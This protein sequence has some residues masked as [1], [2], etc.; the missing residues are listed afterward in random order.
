[1]MHDSERH[2]AAVPDLPEA[3]QVVI[4]DV[5][6][7]E[8]QTVEPEIGHTQFKR[9]Q[10]VEAAVDAVHTAAPGSGETAN[11]LLHPVKTK[12]SMY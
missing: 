5:E 4:N 1:M 3:E 2:L 12:P 9:Q 7:P 11:R 6:S 10:R 8:P